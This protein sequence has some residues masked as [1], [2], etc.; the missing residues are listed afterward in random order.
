[1]KIQNRTRL[2]ILI[3]LILSATVV[4][5]SAADLSYTGLSQTKL[6]VAFDDGSLPYYEQKL[7]LNIDIYKDMS[8]LFI[9]PY[10]SVDQDE[11]DRVRHERIVCRFLSR[12]DGYQS[13]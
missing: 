4:S 8:H 2:P 9:Q 5:L 11:N 7:D 3:L 12:C 6:A 1:M 13:G 10:L